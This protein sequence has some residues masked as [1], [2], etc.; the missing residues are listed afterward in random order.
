MEVCNLDRLDFVQYWP[1]QDLMFVIEMQRDRAWFQRILPKLRQFHEI[2]ETLR[3]DE[4]KL[5]RLRQEPEPTELM[6]K[7]L[8]PNVF[9]VTPVEDLYLKDDNPPLSEDIA[10]Y[11]QQIV[12]V[13]NHD[14]VLG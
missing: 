7:L 10:L 5:E 11:C 8:N 3:H 1:Q 2:M 14:L 4:N 6:R 9:L 12:E 13:N